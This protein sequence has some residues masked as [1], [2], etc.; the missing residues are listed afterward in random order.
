MRKIVIILSVLT[1]SLQSCLNNPESVRKSISNKNRFIE[2][3]GYKIE[4]NLYDCVSDNFLKYAIERN[5]V[6]LPV[7]IVSAPIDTILVHRK[8]NFA[9]LEPYYAF[10]LEGRVVDILKKRYHYVE[11]LKT[12]RHENDFVTYT[13]DQRVYFIEAVFLQVETN[14]DIN[15][16]MLYDKYILC[17]MNKRQLLPPLP[18]A[19]AYEQSPATWNSL[20]DINY[21]N[22][23]KTDDVKKIEINNSYFENSELPFTKG[24][25][26]FF[27]AFYSFWEYDYPEFSPNT[28]YNE[29]SIPTVR[30]LEKQDTTGI[31]D[32]S[33]WHKSDKTFQLCSN[34]I[35][36]KIYKSKEALLNAVGENAQNI[37][38][39][40][41]Y[42]GYEGETW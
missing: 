6:F 20:P 31:F 9:M 18:T 19:I 34:F 2:K 21:W 41:Y 27:A 32:M 33:F 26:V 7:N 30:L 3:N 1:L 42:L 13:E 12:A 29:F 40:F 8:I 4:L 36:K 11:S 35:P 38:E 25:A 23:L 22:Y 10:L 5:N 28:S 17:D 24:D 16:V 15:N 14:G 37:L 39:N